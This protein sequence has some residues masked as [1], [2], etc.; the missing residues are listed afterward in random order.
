MKIGIPDVFSAIQNH[1]LAKKSADI[2]LYEPKKQVYF[3][4]KKH[5]EQ[6]FSCRTAYERFLDIIP[7]E[8][9]LSRDEVEKL[10]FDIN[11]LFSESISTRYEEAMAI[12]A[13]WNA[14]DWD[15]NEL[16]E[17][18]KSSDYESYVQVKEALLDDECTEKSEQVLDDLEITFLN[19]APLQNRIKYN[20]REIE[21]E[22]K[23]M[24]AQYEAAALALLDDMANEIECIS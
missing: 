4:L 5:L 19:Q 10:K 16:F 15:L 7:M 18:I 24:Q 20:Y 17:A 22:Y 8:H 3:Q 11:H 14:V 21:K 13:E 1:C 12:F 23:E 9:T 2:A 6:P